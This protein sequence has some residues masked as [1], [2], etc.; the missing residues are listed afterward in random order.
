MKE[1]TNKDKE[2]MLLTGKSLEELIEMKIQEEYKSLM[3]AP[4]ATIKRID[5]LTKLDAK[6]LFSKKAIF[7]T[8]NK[9]TR[10]E[11]FINGI[12]AEGLIG[13]Q[14]NVRKALLNGTIRAFISGDNYVE[15]LYAEVI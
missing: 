12:Q 7:K 8:F 15:F 10:T 13:L 6:T 1:L 14:E 11:S 3:N 2:K 9:T 4:E 5:D